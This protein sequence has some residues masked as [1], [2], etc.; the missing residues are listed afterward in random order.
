MYM[1]EEAT[2]IYFTEV[3]TDR[4]HLSTLISRSFFLDIEVL[5]L[6]MDCQNCFVAT[7]N[8]VMHQD[9]EIVSNFHSFYLLS[10]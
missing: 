3:L 6:P 5:I 8:F 7:D 9:H 4:K 2:L 1:Q 10:S